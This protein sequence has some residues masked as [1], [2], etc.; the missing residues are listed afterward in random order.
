M[1]EPPKYLLNKREVEISKIK[2]NKDLVELLSRYKL[3]LD[4]SNDDKEILQRYVDKQQ[5]DKELLE[6]QNES[7]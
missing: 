7:N 1:F 2:T 4:L 5:S 6:S 3:Q